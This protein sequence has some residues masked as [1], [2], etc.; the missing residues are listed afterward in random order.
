MPRY[1]FHYRD[2]NDQLVE[3]RLGSL[4]KNLE[5][6]EREAQLVAEEILT[7]E[8]TQAT[9]IFAP[10]C[11]EIEDEAGRVVLYLPFWASIAAPPN[12]ASDQGFA[13]N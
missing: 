3:D 2:T 10:R 1:F 11:L 7:E 12:A 6:A 5:A 8:F 13:L 9:P 4:H